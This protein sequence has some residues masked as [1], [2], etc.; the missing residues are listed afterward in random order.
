MNHPSSPVHC[1]ALLVLLAGL[2]TSCTVQTAT[3]PPTLTLTPTLRSSTLVPYQTR[4]P[5]IDFTARV[6]LAP[7]ATP[8]PS[9]TLT[10]TPSPTL[11]SHV[12]KAGEDMSGIALR[13]RVKLEE[14]KTA[15]PSVNPRLLKIGS[16][17][18]IP[19]TA[20]APGSAPTLA[21]GSPTPSAVP[22]LLSPPRCLPNAEGGATCFVLVSN[23][24]QTA[25]EGVN[26]A[27]RL[28]DA[29]QKEIGHQVAVS[30]LDLLKPE[31][32]L[33]LVAYFPPP[34]ADSFQASAELVSVLPASEGEKRYLP[35][36]VEN[37]QIQIGPDGLAVDIRGDVLAGG[38]K[39]ARQV[40]VAAVAFN[41][42]GEVIG[43]RR[44][45]SAGPLPAGGRM[46]FA[47]RLYSAGGQIDH[48]E[49]LAEAK[50]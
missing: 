8:S 34:L 32:T 3:K 17:L 33:P 4:T 41:A 42:A 44:W 30:P 18:V 48:V 31:A 6:L 23:R 37:Q 25:F 5:T 13:Y 49:L 20:P 21:K 24:Q 1:L 26:V 47:L 36:S 2:S 40:W 38:E 16:S 14:L 39:D 45:E 43:V 50:P 28:R 9:A 12:V 29:S 11:R 35:V 22:V 7:S 15:N 46:P 27:I 10:L 19:G